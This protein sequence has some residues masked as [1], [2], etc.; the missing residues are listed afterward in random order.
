MNTVIL[1]IIEKSN[2]DNMIFFPISKVIAG[3]PSL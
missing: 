2:F 1:Q 3:N